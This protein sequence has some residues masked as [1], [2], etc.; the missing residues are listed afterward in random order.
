MKKLHYGFLT[1]ATSCVVDRSR[2]EGTG[3]ADDA[4]RT[5]SDAP[6]GAK[7]TPDDMS[8]DTHRA[9]DAPNNDRTTETPDYGADAPRTRPDAGPPDAPPDATQDT[10]ADSG[11][12]ANT[13]V[14]PDARE[15]DLSFDAELPDAPHAP[16]DAGAPDTTPPD[17][18]NDVRADAGGDACVP[19]IEQCNGHDDN[20]DGTSDEGCPFCG[21]PNLLANADFE[22]A[23]TDEW[24]ISFSSPGNATVR[25]DD[26]TA[27]DGRYSAAVIILNPGDGDDIR[28]SQEDILLAT[29][30]YELCLFAKSDWRKTIAIVLWASG[31]Q[32]AWR[33]TIGT[34]WEG[35]CGTVTVPENIYDF[36]VIVDDGTTTPVWIDSVSLRACSL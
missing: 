31:A 19:R 22:T 8:A 28:L 10:T 6:T 13:A 3:V 1:L 2:L 25:H 7:G 11:P 4:T 35:H 36:W 24:R 5:A 34:E 9:P 29:G 12:D 32:E 15:Y 30:V 23:F 20:C 26:S 14:S 21:G 33:G 27:H 17:V 16:P 18:G